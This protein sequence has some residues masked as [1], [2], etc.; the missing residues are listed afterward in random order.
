MWLNPPSL[1]VLAAERSFDEDN[2]KLA[3]SHRRHC[4]TTIRYQQSLELLRTDG[5]TLPRLEGRIGPW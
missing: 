2:L 4:R 5:Q 3:G 1:H